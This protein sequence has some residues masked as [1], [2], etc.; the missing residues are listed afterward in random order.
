[1]TG[2]DLKGFINVVHMYLLIYYTFL[3]ILYFI[4]LY[5]AYRGLIYPNVTTCIFF[6]VFWLIFEY[7][8][9]TSHLQQQ[10]TYGVNFE[11][12]AIHVVLSSCGRNANECLE[13][14]YLCIQLYNIISYRSIIRVKRFPP[15]RIHNIISCLFSFYCN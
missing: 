15:P 3:L 11:K 7:N 9:I 6:H 2:F 1:M 4:N 14:I 5:P 13:A 8:K 12:C 10:P